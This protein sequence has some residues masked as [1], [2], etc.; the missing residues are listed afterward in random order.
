MRERVSVNNIVS[1]R[2]SISAV[3]M[4]GLVNVRYIRSLQIGSLSITF[5]AK[6][7]VSLQ[8]PG[9]VL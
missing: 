5:A 7:T 3:A 1:Q 6:E 4:R 2:D 9:E 8:L